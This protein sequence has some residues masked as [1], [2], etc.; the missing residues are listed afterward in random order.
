[1]KKDSIRCV[2]SNHTCLICFSN[3]KLVFNDLKTHLKHV[4]ISSYKKRSSIIAA[5]YST[6]W[7]PLQ[8]FAEMLFNFTLIS[9]YPSH[10][11]F[12][13]VHSFQV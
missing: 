13:L 9:N 11:S 3:L 5:S 2:L 1:M 4:E 12:D 7:L 10:F 8:R 6:N